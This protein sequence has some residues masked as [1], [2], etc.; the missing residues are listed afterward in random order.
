MGLLTL[1]EL[2]GL[3]DPSTEFARQ[4]RAKLS[5]RMY[6]DQVERDALRRRRLRPALPR[7]GTLPYGATVIV[8]DVGTMR[9]VEIPIARISVRRARELSPY[10]QAKI[11]AWHRSRYEHRAAAE[12]WRARRRA[13]QARPQARPPVSS[14]RTRTH[15]Q[16]LQS[17]ARQRA[18]LTVPF[19]PRPTTAPA[20]FTR[21]AVFSTSPVTTPQPTPTGMFLQ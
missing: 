1:N 20:S 6:R 18:A 3:G 4:Q 19:T 14:P 15:I 9:N 11:R 13:L 21:G 7:F 2:S 5:Y 17:A 8:F 10:N 16:E 12:V